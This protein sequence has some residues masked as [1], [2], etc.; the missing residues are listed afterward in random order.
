MT[1]TMPP[2]SPIC[3]VQDKFTSEITLEILIAILLIVDWLGKGIGHY[4][5]KATDEVKIKAD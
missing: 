1:Y 5:M 4:S 2:C 3:S